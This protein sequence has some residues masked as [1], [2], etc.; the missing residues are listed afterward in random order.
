MATKVQKTAISP[1]GSMTLMGHVKE[2]RNRLMI[3]AAIFIV[4]VVIAVAYSA[5]LVNALTLLGQDIGY[6]FV[7]LSPTEKLMQYF[8]VAILTAVVVTVPAALYHI[9]AFAKPGLKKSE[10]RFFAGVMVF[11][12]IL[13]CIGVS[14]AYFISLPFMLNFLLTLEGTDF[15]T[16]QTSLET[17]LNFVITIFTI[18]GVAFE[19]PLIT[20]ILSKMGIANPTFMR[21]GRRIA[22]VLIFLVAAIITPPDIVSQLMVGLPMILLYEISILLSQLTYRKKESDEDEDDYDDEDEDDDEDE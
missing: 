17:Y 22:I 9:W 5:Q 3:C 6:S 7:T 1:D 2:F 8:K 14:F 4:S 21:K 15:I 10:N 19:M 11:G 13:F 20:V 18:F 16:N 12:L